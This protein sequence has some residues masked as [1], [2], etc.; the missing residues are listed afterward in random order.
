MELSA[1]VD[2]D[3][4]E[5]GWLGSK[6]RAVTPRGARACDAPSTAAAR[7]CAALATR[8]KRS[9]R[10]RERRKGAR[11]KARSSIDCASQAAS[12]GAIGAPLFQIPYICTRTPPRVG[13]RRRA[14]V[15][16]ARCGG[17]PGGL[18]ELPRRG[19]DDSWRYAATEPP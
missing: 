19:A 16:L 4:L 14:C 1:P 8:C 5:V 15:L 2:E 10:A 13:R 12:Y 9:P 3:G 7:P 18:G 6:A 11:A 17:L